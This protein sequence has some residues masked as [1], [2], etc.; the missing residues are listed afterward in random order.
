MKKILSV[1]MILALALSLLPAGAL[2]ASGEMGASGEPAA[3]AAKTMALWTTEIG[4][5]S[6]QAPAAYVDERGGL[7]TGVINGYYAG[8]APIILNVTAGADNEA[9]AAEGYVCVDAGA[10]DLDELK[11]AVDTLAARDEELPGDM[12]RLIVCGGTLAAQLAAEGGYVYAAQINDPLVKAEATE[13]ALEAALAKSAEDYALHYTEISITE[14]SNSRALTMEDAETVEKA[15]DGVVEFEWTEATASGEPTGN[16]ASGEASIVGVPD[17]LAVP[18][19]AVEVTPVARAASY[20]RI[21]WNMDNTE[22]SYAAAVGLAESF[23]AVGTVTQI[24]LIWDPETDTLEAFCAWVNRICKFEHDFTV[25]E[26]ETTLDLGNVLVTGDAKWTLSS[27]GTYYVLSS[28]KYIGVVDIARPELPDYQGVSVA[29]PAAYVNGINADGTLDINWEAEITNA[30][31]MT[32]TAATAPIVMQTGATGYSVKCNYLAST[33]ASTGFITVEPGNRG[34]YSQA[35]DAEGNH[36]YTGDAPLCSTD[37]KS[38]VRWL[39]Y[40]HELGYIPGDI[41][42][43]VT[44]GGSG[45]GAHSTLI[46]AGD[47]PYYA[48][49]LY[50]N[51]AL[52]VDCVD[53][54]YVYLDGYSDAVWGSCPGGAVT[55]LEEA[56]MLYE[57]ETWL[58]TPTDEVLMTL[59]D[60]TKVY[61]PAN[62]S[63]FSDFYKLLSYYMVMEFVDFFNAQGLVYD[64]DG[65]GKTEELWL[66]YDPAKYPETSGLHGNYVDLFKQSAEA[67]LEWYLDNIEAATNNTYLNENGESNVEAFMNGH[68]TYLSTAMGP[69]AKTGPQPGIDLMDCLVDSWSVDENGR[70]EV[71]F[72][73][74]GHW[75]VYRGR[76]KTPLAF[77]S[78]SYCTENEVFGDAES[79]YR[80]WDKY[81]LAAMT[82][83]YEELAEAYTSDDSSLYETFDELY[84][85]FANDCIEIVLGQ[86]QSGVVTQANIDAVLATLDYVDEPVV[87]HNA[88]WIYNPMQLFLD[89][90]ATLPTWVWTVTG[91]ADSDSSNLVS[92]NDAIAL[93]MGGTDAV[94]AWTWGAG[95]GSNT[96]LNTTQN[97]T[98]DQM[99]ARYAE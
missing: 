82:K 1:L 61:V 46:C 24:N 52:G 14:A 38:V 11:A 7:T 74:I 44:W 37:Q 4:G 50:R 88:V 23:E 2:A 78:M 18:A 87:N 67:Q 55:N 53:G 25:E 19:D 60:G 51:G 91:A 40:N 58:S 54:E 57:F 10:A 42:R 75:E 68:Y 72:K 89:G 36:Y 9:L 84:E 13:A 8:T 92:M 98:I 59:E 31:G 6:V 41:D 65:D 66:G 15:L 48:E 26:I 79:D 29:V 70:H 97:G 32:Y 34:K 85:S 22:G 90:T 5:L 49:Y 81:C 64:V 94:F 45:G 35:Y 77:D 71:T 93:E 21:H 95:H 99:M 73:S 3:P 62:L 12:G 56:N 16:Y 27:G 76:S 17:A 83:H 43:I 86:E 20:V 47:S 96:P 30:N 69:D 39:R 63:K 28:D 33:S 80:H